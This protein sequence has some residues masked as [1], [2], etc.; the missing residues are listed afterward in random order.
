[1]DT[2][3]LRNGSRVCLTFRAPADFRAFNA[4]AG[5]C[6]CADR[7]EGG[8]LVTNAKRFRDI[9]GTFDNVVIER[10]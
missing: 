2:K 8:Y 6:R 3:A 5:A 10:I 9:L 1:M 7:I 4:T